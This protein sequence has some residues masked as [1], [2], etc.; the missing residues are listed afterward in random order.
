M[1]NSRRRPTLSAS[2]GTVDVSTQRAAAMAALSTQLTSEK[3]LPQAAQSLFGQNTSSTPVGPRCDQAHVSVNSQRAAAMAALSSVLGT[4][5]GATASNI[6]ECLC[7]P[8]LSCRYKFSE[9]NDCSY[10][11]FMC[12]I[13]RERPERVQ[14]HDHYLHVMFPLELLQIIAPVEK[15]DQYLPVNLVTNTQNYALSRS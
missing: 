7:A 6:G 8:S 5:P 4:K 1:Q 13:L 3:K 12:I 2:A 11:R 15:V 9:L 10:S 14:G